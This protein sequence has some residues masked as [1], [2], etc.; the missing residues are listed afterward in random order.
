MN[1]RVWTV[2]ALISG[3]ATLP[4]PVGEQID[5]DANAQIRE[6]GL[7]HSQLMRTL[8]FLSDVYGP[9]LT[10]SP[11]LKA[12]GEWAVKTMESWGFSNG[13]L[14]PWD[15]GHPGWVNER[16]SVHVVSPLKAPLVVEPLAW[17]PG[18]NGTLTASAV[19]I[20]LPEGPPM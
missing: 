14:E 15:F 13:R 12:A 6:E 18:T 20:S 9:R 17:T 2:A 7:Q 1:V 11:S 8:H 10:G 5:I 19:N 4:F 3:A 16:T